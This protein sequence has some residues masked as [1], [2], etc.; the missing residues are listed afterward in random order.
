MRE[1]GNDGRHG[2][3]GNGGVAGFTLL[4]LMLVIVVIGISSMLV[5]PSLTSAYGGTSLKASSRNVSNLVKF[6]RST[7]ITRHWRCKLEYN[8]G[9]RQWA[10]TAETKYGTNP[11]E[12]TRVPVPGN[13]RDFVPRNIAVFP[14]R[15]FRAGM[16][17]E[18][19]VSIEF[20]PDGTCDEAFIY[21]GDP[22]GRI[23]TVALVPMTSQAIVADFEAL[24]IYEAA[25]EA[26]EIER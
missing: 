12:Y 17:V 7:A 16:E 5:I 24:T 20:R 4:E 19:A 6:T 26:Y 15:V 3:H 2:S 1:H 25:G 9:A 10:V 21:L 23:H 14:L 11:G 22:Q 8:A 13:I 18:D